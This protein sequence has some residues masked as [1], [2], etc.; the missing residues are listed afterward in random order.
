M[1][2]K[3]ANLLLLV[4]LVTT[5]CQEYSPYI[6]DAKGRVYIEPK[7]TGI[8]FTEIKEWTVG[9]PLNQKISKGF[10]V[11]IKFPIIKTEDLMDLLEYRKID[12]WLVR[13]YRRTY[14]SSEI[15]GHLYIPIVL[16]GRQKT[17]MRVR[18]LENGFFSIYYAA[19]AMSN[20]FEHFVCPAFDHNFVLE[21]VKIEKRGTS[22]AKLVVSSVEMEEIRGEIAKF[23]YAPQIIN[24]G[25]KLSGTYRVELALFNYGSKTR[26]S[27]FLPLQEVI[28]VGPEKRKVV[29]GCTGFQIPPEGKKIDDPI[30]LFKWKK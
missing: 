11:K 30:K 12:S 9:Q 3:F 23:G 6:K 15:L 29:K 4:L 1:G 2:M 5:G 10:M 25:M 20:R 17:G 16:P 7:N 13:I 24:G 19:A 26:Y 27:S 22:L 28:V 8:E 18:Q 21:D 14:S